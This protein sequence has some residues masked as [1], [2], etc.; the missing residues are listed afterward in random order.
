M[1]TLVFLR[2]IQR[3]LE[4][5]L[6]VFPLCMMPGTIGRRL[7]YFY[8]RQRVKHMGTGVIIDVGVQFVQPEH[9]SIGDNVWIDKYVVLLAGPPQ[10]TR[11]GSRKEN[12]FFPLEE[13]ELYIGNN[14]H[15]APHVVIQGH[16]GVWL[17]NNLTVA[18]GCRIYSLSNHYRNLNDE[19]DETDYWFTSMASPQHQYLISGA[20]V[21]E[22]AS[23][24]GLNSVVLPGVTIYEGSW[25]ATMSLVT[26]DIPPWVIAGG[27]PAIVRKHRRQAAH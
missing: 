21:M 24:L 15:I 23:A 9:V 14:V 11:K 19:F 1:N 16:G 7:R 27:N 5:L 3:E 2:Q 26:E 25:V 10:G 18:S 8:W 22:D 4:G 12:S 20:V 13:G 6:I 17:G